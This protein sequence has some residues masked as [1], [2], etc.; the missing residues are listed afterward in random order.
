MHLAL[1]RS[2]PETGGLNLSALHWDMIC[3]LRRGSGGL[4]GGEIYLDG[5]LFQSGGQ[6]V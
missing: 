2:Y 1:G 5:E 4:G 6:F 3:D